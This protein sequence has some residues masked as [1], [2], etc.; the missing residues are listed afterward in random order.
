MNN[1]TTVKQTKSA[2][3][4]HAVLDA[5]PSASPLHVGDRTTR[6][7]RLLEAL[8][9][10]AQR[11]LSHGFVPD[12][13]LFAQSVRCVSTKHDTHLQREGLSL[14]YTAI[15]ALGLASCTPAEQRETLDGHLSRDLM[16]RLA[17]EA[18]DSDDLGSIALSAWAVAEITGAPDL[19][20]VNRMLQTFA[21][22]DP[23]PTVDTAWALTA[24]V[25]A[26]H[27]AELPELSVQLA[28]TL[29]TTAYERLMHGEGA[30]GIFAHAIPAASLG[31]WRAHVG[32]FA[33]Q[34]Y[35]IQALARWAAH[36][37]NTE[38]LAAADRTAAQICA[39]QGDAG[40]WWWHYDARTGDVIE[41]FPVYSVHQ[42]AMAPM[43]LSELFAA[44]GTDYSE[45]IDSG[46]SWLET[47]PEI[48]DELISKQF[49]LIWRK[50]GRHEPRK[51]SRSINAVTTAMHAGWRVKG[52]DTLFPVGVVDRE[53]RPY[54]L[55]WLLYAWLNS[56]PASENVRR[57]TIDANTTPVS[58]ER[59]DS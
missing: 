13:G 6:T 42:H 16:P 20:L 40:E 34:V 17:D 59:N 30:Q 45:A 29:A 7:S 48:G 51:A 9:T 8:T 22:G 53:C 46:L 38:A 23:L 41:G 19:R 35:P 50:V 33:D 54:E 24:A 26:L 31:R 55:G 28:T 57:G 3:R 1:R 39:L 10:L 14:R 4:P 44:G 15:A 37:G 18:S 32:C 43:A 47:H 49:S 27:C 21:S 52:V 2:A 58:A 56:A 11:G 25:A 5:S 36:S 12:E